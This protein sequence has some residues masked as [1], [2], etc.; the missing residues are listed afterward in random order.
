MEL[1]QILIKDQLKTHTGLYT[2]YIKRILIVEK[3]SVR[4]FYEGRG[5]T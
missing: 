3:D 2:H 5:I 1:I 4:N